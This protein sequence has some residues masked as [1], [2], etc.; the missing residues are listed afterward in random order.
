[1]AAEHYG[2]RK[3]AGCAAPTGGG[4]QNGTVA[5]DISD[6]FTSLEKEKEKKQLSSA[7]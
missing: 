2:D 1:M 3:E 4:P 7:D 6:S 5:G